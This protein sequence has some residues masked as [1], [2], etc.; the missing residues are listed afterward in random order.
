MRE[1]KYSLTPKKFFLIVFDLLCS[2]L[3]FLF[4]QLLM[5][6]TPA[7][8][9]FARWLGQVPV[10]LLLAL[11]MYVGFGLYLQM[12]LHASILQYLLVPVSVFVLS[13]LVWCVRVFLFMDAVSLAELWIQFSSAVAALLA[14]RVLYR[15]YGNRRAGIR[16]RLRGRK[17]DV[18]TIRVLIVGAGKAG[19]RLAEDLEEINGTRFPVAFVDDNPRT[20]RLKHAGIP[21]LGGR[22]EIPSI[23]STYAIDEIIIAIPSLGA[24]ETK[25]LVELCQKTHCRIRI[26]PSVVALTEDEVGLRDVKDIDIDDLLGREPVTIASDSVSA[27][28]AGKVVL[29][30]GGGGSIGSEICR[31]IAKCAPKQLILLD[32]YEN[33]AYA[34]QQE[35]HSLYGKNLDLK[36]LIASV[37]DERRLEEIYAE[38]RPQIIYHAAAHKHVPL[39][40]DSPE[41]AIKNNVRGTYHVVKLAGKYG[42]E[43]FVLISTDKAVNPSSVMGAS[44][45]LAEMTVLAVSKRYPDLKCAMVRFGNVLGSSGSVVPLFK[46]QIAYERRVTVTDPE[47][48]RYFM[49]IPEAVCLVLQASVYANKAEIFVLDMG[50]PVKIVDLAETMIRLSGYEPNVDIPIEFIGLRPGEKM[51]EELYFD[52]ETLDTTPHEKIMKLKQVEDAELLAKE[53]DAL[54]AKFGHAY[55]EIKNGILRKIIEDDCAARAPEGEAP[56]GEGDGQSET[57]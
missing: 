48:R 45:R 37:R 39:M 25:R 50:E 8:E 6:T 1:T 2:A 41:E 32:I 27:M 33:N 31:Q 26:L 13:L 7:A 18:K 21:V 16:E 38:Y 52:R 17:G 42:A 43:R 12:W 5:R 53:I 14:I 35:L 15:L 54:F 10:I 11:L 56:A 20:H 3:S 9:V 47:M 34:L 22:D 46:R 30:T 40:E 29:V 44:K 4:A 51:F 57:A 36:V 49:T 19:S 24:A 55:P 28:L 23:C